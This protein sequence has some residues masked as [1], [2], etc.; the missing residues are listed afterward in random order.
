MRSP[1]F[2][3]FLALCTIACLCIAILNLPLLQY[4]FG[5]YDLSP[6]ID[7]GWRVYMGQV[8]N[9]DFI[10]TFPPILYLAVALA[11][12][13]FGIHWLAITITGAIFPLVLTAAGL[14]V[15]CTLRPH[16]P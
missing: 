9:R 11:F 2:P 3:R 8:P 10:C 16:I 13:V 14:H 15:L 5:G 12:H 6:L 4:R 7:S 1:R